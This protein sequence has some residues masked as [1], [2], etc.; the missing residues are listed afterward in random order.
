MTNKNTKP[1]GLRLNNPCNLRIGQGK[2][3]GEYPT[4]KDKEF[5]EFRDM[6]W[7]LR[8][9]LHLLVKTYYTMHHLHTVRKIINRWA[10]PKENDTLA[11]IHIMCKELGIKADAEIPSS[12][13]FWTK[14]LDAMIFV[15]NGKRLEKKEISTIVKFYYPLFV[16]A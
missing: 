9:A 16:G 12:V 14:F 7:G 11:Y 10:P 6:R 3:V 8:A 13:E 1:R 2:F 4:S 5:R 15:E